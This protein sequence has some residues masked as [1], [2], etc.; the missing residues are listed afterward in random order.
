MALKNQKDKVSYS[1]GLNIGAG[2]RAQGVEIDP[3]VFLLGLQD[4][5]A[6]GKTL[7]TIDEALATLK[8]WRNEMQAR[9]E[10]KRKQQGETN[11]SEGE[12]FLAANKSK[13]G[14][15]TLPSGLQY[16]VLTEGTGPKPAAT[17]TVEC[18][19]RGTLLNGRE[20]DSSAKHGQPAKFLVSGLIKGWA[21][22]L[23][24][25]PVGSKWQL[26]VPPDLAY[27]DRGA[28]NDIGPN[29]TLVFEVE[30]LSI[31]GK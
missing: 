7:M 13:E 25:M 27:T 10:A 2:M 31:Q 17:D 23:Q 11:K 4:A 19:Y 15:V 5:L 8:Q 6:G 21:E 18:N 9:L 22:A 26:I 1:L 20:F 28:G 12:A 16:K 30:L 24:L 29:A 14:V 3:N